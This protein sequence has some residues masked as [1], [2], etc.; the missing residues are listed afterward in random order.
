MEISGE[1]LTADELASD[2]GPVLERLVLLIRSLNIL[3]PMSRTSSA[4]LVTLERN[5]P[6]RLTALAASERVSQ[7][8]MTQLIGK[9][10]DAG[11]VRRDAD[12]ADG[13]VVQVSI[14]DTGRALL[15]I[16]RVERAKRL[17][18]L[19]AQLSPAHQEL[20]AAALPALS[21]LAD[22]SYDAPLP[23]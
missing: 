15:A 1:S 5:G 21:E 16:R 19:L 3:N 12:P 14:T 7:P 20:L 2:L 11:I 10:E 6:S 17:G 8:A 23:G 18:S 13:R 9:L 22:T 4:T